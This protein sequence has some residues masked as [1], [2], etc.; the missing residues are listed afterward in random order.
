ME[1]YDLEYAKL[2]A[3]KIKSAYP[4]FEDE[5]FAA[6]IGCALKDQ[7]FSERMDLFADAIDKSLPRD[8]RESLN[9]LRGILG[10]ELKTDSGMFSDGWWLWPVGRYVEKRG[11][12]SVDD[13]I[14]FIEEL[15]KRFTGEF[16]IR[17][18]LRH[19]PE[20]VMPAMEKWSVS[21][22]VHVRRLSSEGLR[23]RLP[24]AKKIYVAIEQFEIYVRILTNLKNDASKFVQ[25]SVG[26]NLNDLRKEYPEKAREIIDAWMED[27]PTKATLWIIKHGLRGE[28][29]KL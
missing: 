27:S 22:N 3:G 6:D 16:A 26:N 13:S 5:A 1:Y 10:G 20:T 21:G 12:E 24:W 9:I 23:I 28:N 25:K 15:T 11:V 2:I 7:E 4:S 19:S 14:A 17:P 18:L 29:K 8:Y